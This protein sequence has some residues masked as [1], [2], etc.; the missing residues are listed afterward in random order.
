MKAEIKNGRQS[1][2][3]CMHF[4]SRHDSEGCVKCRNNNFSEF[5]SVSIFGKKQSCATQHDKILDN[6]V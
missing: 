4:L 5:V 1:C 2:F 3:G 6:K